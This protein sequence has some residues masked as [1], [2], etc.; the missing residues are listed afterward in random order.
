V[1]KELKERLVN[2]LLTGSQSLMSLSMSLSRS[3]DKARATAR[4]RAFWLTILLVGSTAAGVGVTALLVSRGIT[5]PI[6][7]LRHGAEL[8]AGGHLDYKIGSTTADE[9]GELARTFDEMAA[10]LQ[11]RAE[12][13]DRALEALRLDEERLEALVKLNQM[14][15]VSQKQLTDFALEAA[16]LLTGSK[17]GYLAFMNEDET[18]MT[19]HSWSAQA[20]AECAIMD[21]PRVYPVETTGLWGDAIRQRKPIITNDYA[22]PNPSKKGYPEGH[23]PVLRHMNAPIFDGDHI[24]ALAGVGNKETPYD[25]ADVRQLTLLMQGMWRLIQRREAEEDLRKHRNHLEELVADRTAELQ[26]ATTALARSNAELE[27]FAYVA[28]HDLREPLR[29]I[30]SFIQLLERHC[31]DKLDADDTKYIAFVVDGAQRMAQLIN[32][33]LQYA[34]VSSHLK[35]FVP[36]DCNSIVQVVLQDM[37]ITIAENQAVV[38]IEGTLPTVR[39]NNV[40]L[41]QLF[42]NL[43]ANAIKFRRPD[44]PP[45]LQIAATRNQQD[46]VF[47]VQDNGIGIEPVDFER[48]F[49][50]FQRLHARDKYPG[51]GIGLAICKKIVECHGG[52]IWVESKPGQG[53]SFVFSIPAR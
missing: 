34:R 4:R 38:T 25:E 52:R 50:I 29:M 15:D 44:E 42:Q 31:R 36:V 26:Q 28:S 41:T 13:R 16:V 12:E 23:V 10:S 20:M 33:L 32:D 48:I 2:H 21:K 49:V 6:Q 39:G 46:W 14:T 17:I 5:K 35:E 43:I 19:M 30:T 8:L 24:V 37:A 9:V 47:R 22:A 18:V 1:A 51:T 3:C 40:Q 7:N 27:Q 11:R 45:C 53:A